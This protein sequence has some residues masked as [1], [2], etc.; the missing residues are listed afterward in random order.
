MKKEYVLVRRT[1]AERWAARKAGKQE[2]NFLRIRTALEDALGKA[3]GEED[4][5]IPMFEGDLEQGKT[6]TDITATR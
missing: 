1:K 2:R 5:Q 4:F 6:Y 3:V